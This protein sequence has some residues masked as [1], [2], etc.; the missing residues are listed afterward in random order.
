[1]DKRMLEE[2]RKMP[3]TSEGELIEEFFDKTHDKVPCRFNTT[4]SSKLIPAWYSRKRQ[5]NGI[6]SNSSEKKT[7][8]VQKD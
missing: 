5:H 7:K 3:R 1:M 8:I 6:R 2:R 4:C